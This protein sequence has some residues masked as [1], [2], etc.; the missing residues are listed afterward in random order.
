LILITQLRK[1]DPNNTSGLMEV[2]ND[3][4]I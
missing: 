3:P 2:N 1:P 4:R